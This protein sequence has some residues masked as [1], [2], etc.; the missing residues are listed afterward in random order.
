M[1]KNKPRVLGFPYNIVVTSSNNTPVT[2]AS[3]G[4][5]LGDKW[6]F[7]GSVVALYEG[8]A[9]IFVDTTKHLLLKLLL[10]G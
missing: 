2:D 6:Q 8:Y 10:K 3:Y 4:S 9:G 7:T 1:P 5:V